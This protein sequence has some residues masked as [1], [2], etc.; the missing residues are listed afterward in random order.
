MGRAVLNVLQPGCRNRAR[1]TGTDGNELH[2]SRAAGENGN[3]PFAVWREPTRASFTQLRW[4][5]AVDFANGKGIVRTLR[6]HWHLR[7][8]PIAHRPKC[9]WQCSNRAR[10]G[11]ALPLRRWWPSARR[12]WSRL[13]RTRPSG[14]TSSK[15]MPSGRSRILPSSSRQIHRMQVAI[16]AFFDG[17]K[18]DLF[19]IGAPSQAVLRFPLGR[20]HARHDR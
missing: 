6:L 19:S 7:T 8:R 13:T 11:R 1:L 9:L 20:K 5:V 2:L 12:S 10:K 15:V 18:P 3:H 14:A 4:E 16:Q 17:G